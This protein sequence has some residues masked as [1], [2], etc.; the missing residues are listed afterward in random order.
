M[1]RVR[2]DDNPGVDVDDARLNIG[3]DTDVFAILSGEQSESPTLG[4]PKIARWL[5]C[6]RP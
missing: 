1:P 5:D 4:G 3:I 2:T 6:W